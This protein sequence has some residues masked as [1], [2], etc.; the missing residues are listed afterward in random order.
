[1]LLSEDAP[2]DVAR[3]LLIRRTLTVV[4]EQDYVRAYGPADTPEDMLVRVAGMRSRDLGRALPRRKAR[5]G[6]ITTRCAGGTRGSGRSHSAYS[7]LLPS[8]SCVAWP[9]T[10]RTLAVKK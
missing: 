4:P 7:P 6:S 5:W 2:V 3:W 1:V 9:V 10:L 8:P